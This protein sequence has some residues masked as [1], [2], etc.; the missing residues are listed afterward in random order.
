MYLVK[1][2]YQVPINGLGY[3]CITKEMLNILIEFSTCKT[4]CS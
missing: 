4:Q 2:K 3:I 1:G